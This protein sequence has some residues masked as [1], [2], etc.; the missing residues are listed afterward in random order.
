MGTQ[1]FLTGQSQWLPTCSVALESIFKMTTATNGKQLVGFSTN[2]SQNLSKTFPEQVKAGKRRVTAVSTRISTAVDEFKKAKALHGKN[3]EKYQRMV[4]DT[5]AAIKAKYAASEAEGGRTASVDKDAAAITQGGGVD[6]F[7]NRSLNKMLSKIAPEKKLDDRCKDLVRELDVTERGLIASGKRLLV[8]RSDLI[9]DIS[10]AFAELEELE[11]QRLTFMK[12]GLSRFCLAAELIASQQNETITTVLERTNKLDATV[13]SVN[14]MNEIDRP[15]NI[16]SPAAKKRAEVN[17]SDSDDDSSSGSELVVLFAK[18]EKLGEAMEYFKNL[19]A[20]TAVSLTEVAETEASFSR[21]AQKVLD[22]HGYTRNT[23]SQWVYA[24]DYSTIPML[25]EPAPV[26]SAPLSAA[27]GAVGATTL[28]LTGGLRSAEFLSR[29]ESPMTKAGWELVVSQLG[30]NADLMMRSSEVSVEDV[31]QQLEL[32]IQRLEIGR[33]ELVEK[34][35]SNSK[36]VDNAKMEV[37]RLS[38]KLAKCKAV[39]KERRETVKQVKDVMLSDSMEGG[40]GDA[41]ANVVIAAVAQDAQNRDMVG[42]PEGP[43]VLGATLDEPTTSSAPIESAATSGGPFQRSKTS[44]FRKGGLKQVVGLE[45]QADRASRIEK[46]VATLEE[47]QR[48]L[49]ESLAAA[50]LSL[51]AITAA[52]KTQVLPIFDAT[53]EFLSTDLVTI[54][55]A[56]ECLMSWK[57]DS[58]ASSKNFNRHVKKAGEEI[59]IPKDVVAY[60]KA[61]QTAAEGIPKEAPAAVTLATAG[62]AAAMASGLVGTPLSLLDVPE[63]E[64]FV[65]VSSEL[66]T[67]ERA[68]IASQQPAPSVYS[69]SNL[70]MAAYSAGGTDV[71]GAS[72]PP[73]GYFNRI[74]RNTEDAAAGG[75]ASEST[76]SV[77]DE[78]SL[79]SQP[80]AAD[81]TTPAGNNP[82]L[83]PAVDSTERELA[84]FGLNANDKVIESYSCALY[85]KKG[86][87]THG[88]YAF[89]AVVVLVSVGKILDFDSHFSSFLIG[90]IT[91]ALHHAALRG[92]LRLARD[93]R[94]PAAARHRGGQPREHAVLRAQRAVDRDEGRHGVLPGIIHRPRA[95]L[96]EPH[97]PQRRWQAHGDAAGIRRNRRT[98]QP[99][100]W[101]PDTQQLL[102]RGRGG[103][104]DRGEQCRG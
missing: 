58:L 71:E 39:L 85:P 83:T 65:P 22:R 62:N 102:R 50:E 8:Q 52:A 2:L 11:T 42:S 101:L 69:I 82:P 91:Q 57:S 94:A 30:N 40:G 27:I 38:T 56:I 10:K 32:V 68:L 15:L 33:K 24:A 49:T 96:R 67:Q 41:F 23:A 45:T 73:S 95:V 74:R 81:S 17:N 89:L 80:S 18:A 48:E 66:I 88:R 90:E 51:A 20:R 12:E 55:N 93:P 64:P 63:M 28:A 13:E 29:F 79:K 31:S 77:A 103:C 5:E 97:Q 47:E 21:S 53:R 3:L 37:S 86:L 92:I 34:L 99:G 70:A 72:P 104:G 76:T 60:I 43:S 25:A 6:N 26:K 14:L 87:L 59:E 9:I 36:M 84:K 19:V 100:V 75:L 78:D 4:T 54:K 44:L 1:S 61:V 16:N 98:P 46:Q 35:M 7:M